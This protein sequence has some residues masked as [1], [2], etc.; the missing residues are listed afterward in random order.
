MLG[1]YVS[2]YAMEDSD[3]GNEFILGRDLGY[4][5]ERIRYN[6]VSIYVCLCLCCKLGVCVS[7]FTNVRVDR[8]D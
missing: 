2:R 8:I 4:R 3:V 7:V 6:C 1:L 5:R